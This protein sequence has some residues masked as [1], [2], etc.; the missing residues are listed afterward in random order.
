MARPTKSVNQMTMNMTKDERETRL[1]AEA[2]VQAMAPKKPKPFSSLSKDEKKIFNKLVKLNDTFNEADSASLSILA[3]SQFRYN[4]LSDAL[5]DLNP[6]D[7]RTVSLERRIHAYDK[8][9]VQHM[10]LLCIPLS[11]RLRLANDMAKVEIE[12]KKM[13]QMNGQSIKAV[14]PL[15]ALLNDD[16]DDE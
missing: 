11:H 3:R 4:A 14:N 10:S 16:D 2:I 5:N 1:E 12:R 15:L 9:I 6:L 13:K 7:E 8:A